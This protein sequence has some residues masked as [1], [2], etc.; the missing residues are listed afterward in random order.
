MQ[1]ALDVIAEVSTLFSS[2]QTIHKMELRKVIFQVIPF[3]KKPPILG[4]LAFEHLKE[5]NIFREQETL[6]TYEDLSWR[7]VKIVCD[8]NEFELSPFHDLV[9]GIFYSIQS[10]EREGENAGEVAFCS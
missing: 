8:K 9:Y 6:C 7:Q 3:V 5:T 10:K 1:V 4:L 2:Q